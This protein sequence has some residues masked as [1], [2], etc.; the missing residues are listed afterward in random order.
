M[1]TQILALKRK[2][3]CFFVIRIPVTKIVGKTS[4]LTIFCFWVF[5][6]NYTNLEF[7]LLIQQSH[8]Q[9]SILRNLLC[10][11]HHLILPEKKWK[12]MILPHLTRYLSCLFWLQK[13]LK[14]YHSEVMSNCMPSKWFET[15]NCK[16]ILLRF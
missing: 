1:V 9:L 11:A 14:L 12:I 4:I 5:P 2:E 7:M 16:I 10:K 13:L 8:A 15:T 6:L 3:K